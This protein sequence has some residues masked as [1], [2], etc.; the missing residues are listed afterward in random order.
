MKFVLVLSI[1][2]ILKQIEAELNGFCD[3]SNPDSDN[4]QSIVGSERSANT[5]GW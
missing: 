3:S 4:P 5:F 1:D 2:R